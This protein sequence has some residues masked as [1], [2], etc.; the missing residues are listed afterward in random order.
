[1]AAVLAPIY[2]ILGKCDALDRVELREVSALD[3]GYNAAVPSVVRVSAVPAAHC[4]GASSQLP[5][6]NDNAE[7]QM[8]P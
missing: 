4:S 2:G 5:M 7:L 8:K 6:S 3:T 1:M